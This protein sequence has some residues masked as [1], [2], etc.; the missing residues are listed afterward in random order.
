MVDPYLRTSALQQLGLAGRSVSARGEAG[1]TLAERPFRAIVDLRGKPDD[2]AF[3]AAANLAL[4]F[5][6]PNEPN[7]TVASGKAT[8]FWLSPEEWWI[9]LPDATA[10]ESTDLTEKLSQALAEQFAAVTDVGESRTCIAVG[11][12]HAAD[13]LAKGCPLDLHPRA[14][15]AGACAQSLLAKAGVLIHKLSEDEG[16]GPDFELY[17]LRSFADYTWRW[18]EDAAREYGLAILPE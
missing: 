18:L 2:R 9:V 12:P 8:A 3:M 7:T 14:F 16:D 15:P 1:V 13:L 11:G 6:L 17:V 10:E 5:T 4:G